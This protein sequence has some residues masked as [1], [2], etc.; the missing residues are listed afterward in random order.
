[1][2][3]SN[4]KTL[5]TYEDHFETYITETAQV[6]NGFQ[7]KWLEYLL[8]FCEQ[9]SA[10]LEVGSAFGR[11]ATFITQLG[12][13]NFTPTDAF[14]AAVTFLR[15]HGFDN[16][17]KLN[18]L[19][20][21]ITHKYDLVIAAAVLLHFTEPELRTSLLKIAASLTD[22]GIF[23]FSVK[24]GTGEEWSSDKV[25]APRFFHYWTVDAIRPVLE[26]CGYEIIDVRYGLDGKWLLVTASMA[27]A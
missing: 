21:E 26:D 1:M 8:S 11:D 7:Q 5:Q 15:E 25:G 12:F 19:E 24:S 3:G 27:S 13:R 4:A 6:T 16:T 18:L 22:N 14:D 9:D 10:I 2:T 20:D 17:Q 23:G